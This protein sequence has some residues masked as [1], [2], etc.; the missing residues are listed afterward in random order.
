MRNSKFI[1]LGFS[2]EL[3]DKIRN[4]SLGLTALR[5]NSQSAL[6][7]IGFS[8]SEA[9]LI[10]EKVNRKP[11]PTET[12]KELISQSGGICC[13]CA[14]GNSAQPF[15]VHHIDDY[16]N[17][18]DHSLNNLMLVCPTHHVQIHSCKASV[19]EQQAV[20]RA[21]TNLWAI[22]VSYR[23]RDLQFPFGAFEYI[24]YDIYGE[25]TDIFSFGPAK[26]G[27]CEQLAEGE[28]LQNAVSML[29]NDHKML[30]T[31]DSG[32]G[33][34]TLSLAIGAKLAS[35][36]VYR[37]L[38]GEKESLDSMREILA[39]VAT[40]VKPILL[41][42]DDANIKLT[43]GHIEKILGF[44]QVDKKLIVVTTK[45]GLAGNGNLEPRVANSVFPVTW[46]MLRTTVKMNLLKHER[47]IMQ[48]LKAKGLDN[49]NGDRIGYSMTDRKLA[50]VLDSYA[51]GTNSVWEFIFMLASGEELLNG[52]L[53]ELYSIDRLDLL[54]IFL[55]VNQI[56]SAEQGTSI[57]EIEKFFCRHSHFMNQAKPSIEW[58]TSTMNDLFKWRMVRK[59]R[60]RFNLAHR[61]LAIKFIELSYWRDKK[62]TEE[63]LNLFFLDKIP[64]R[65]LLIL[66]SWLS[67]TQLRSYT[68]AWKS[69]RTLENWTD[70]S[71]LA[72]NEGLMYLT[73]MTDILHPGNEE[74]L[75][76]ILKDKGERLGELINKQQEGTLYSFHKLSM[77]IRHNAPEIWPSLLDKIDKKALYHL[78]R[79][80]PAWEM[81]KI[82]WL[83]GSIRESGYI[84][85][86]VSTMSHFSKSDLT[87]MAKRVEKGD[88]SSFSDLMHFWRSYVENISVRDFIEYMAFIP[89]LLKDCNIR[90]F[91]FSFYHHGFEEILA[92]P[93]LID[94]ILKALDVEKMAE[95]YV[96]LTPD[97]WGNLLMLS[98]LS[99]YGRYPAIGSFLSQL[100]LDKLK[101]NVA[102]YYQDNLYSFRLMIHQLAYD[103]VRKVEI[104]LMLQPFLEVAV[105]KS[106]SLNYHEHEDVL[107]AFFKIDPDWVENYCAKVSIPFVKSAKERI[108]EDKAQTDGL[109]GNLANLEPEQLDQLLPLYKITLAE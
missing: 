50:Y 76:H 31:G 29:Q 25:V 106:I 73:I 96:S 39:F 34:T 60:D 77:A 81:E 61:M 53:S 72:V 43:S 108:T 82:N 83:L 41:I 103:K 38:V 75:N 69:S 52:R 5:G 30:M 45:V 37:Y 8:E 26:P 74:I 100:N 21:W 79:E 35:T 13:Y 99:E 107:D 84:S 90:N 46:N 64:T 42:I 11:I 104:S 87:Y 95:D 80:A 65:E 102:L 7:A 28:L 9:R 59:R 1:A 32:S 6:L 94:N 98:N 54:V 57:E 18:Q 3:I 63:I 91:K 23:D 92:F 27:M 58:I 71:D 22:A 89:A 10:R 70:I 49:Y 33:K 20:K 62:N 85:W 19:E 67:G 109:F 14:N 4:K 101:Q 105:L 16:S 15:Q 44:A 2:T 86:I 48:Y 97:H 78:I 24:D 12:I 17:S 40:A 36:V 88:I 56:A 68:S 55:G 47:E 66:W 51:L 93:D